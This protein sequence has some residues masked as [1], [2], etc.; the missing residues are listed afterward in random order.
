MALMLACSAFAFAPASDAAAEDNKQILIPAVFAGA[1]A[2]SID[3]GDETTPTEYTPTG[4]GAAAIEHT[5]AEAGKY[6]ITITATTAD[7]E[8][9]TKLNYDTATGNWSIVKS[10]SK[11]Q[12]SDYYI[13]IALAAL[14]IIAFVYGIFADRRA[15][16]VSAALI[17]IALI[18]YFGGWTTF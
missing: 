1:T 15:W 2:V 14:A 7:G 9:V 12:I 3:W 4:S 11:T 5:Y 13:I 10:D 18:C 8:M 17:V 16:F 6:V